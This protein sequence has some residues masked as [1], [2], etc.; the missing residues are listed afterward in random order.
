MV[1]RIDNA[2]DNQ[3]KS[4]RGKVG[5][6]DM[7][8]FMIGFHKENELETVEQTECTYWQ[9]ESLA[10]EQTEMHL[11]A[12]SLPAERNETHLLVVCQSSC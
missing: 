1:H 5:G 3:G 9:S 4:F 2:V 11:L 7:W 8:I 6:G 10:V 12:V